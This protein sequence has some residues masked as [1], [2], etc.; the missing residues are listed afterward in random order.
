MTTA[1]FGTASDVCSKR[2]P[3]SASSA[4]MRRRQMPW[5]RTS[6]K[7]PTWSCWT[8]TW[9]RSRRRFPRRAARDRGFKGRIV[10]VTAG[11]SQNDTMRV[12]QSGVSGIF[13]KHN[14]PSTLIAA[15]RQVTN[16]AIW[17]DDRAAKAIIAATTARTERENTSRSL[18]ER[19]Q[20]ILK[21]LFEGL[22][23]KEIAAKI[24]I[25]EISVKW[26]L[27]QL[28][29]R[30]GCE[31]AASWCDSPSNTAFR[32]GNR[33]AEIGDTVSQRRRRSRIRTGNPSRGAACRRRR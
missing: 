31:P 11:M 28:L 8:T 27:Q 23:N 22:A 18:T 24:N 33:T 15:I 32:T 2:N 10:M 5:S 9:E 26:S 1:Y 25:P 12:F 7:A 17:M 13:L 14:P 20:A 3:I 30:P 16:G 21:A 4:V 19:D 6:W 29:T